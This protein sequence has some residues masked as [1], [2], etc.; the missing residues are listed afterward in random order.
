MSTTSTPAGARG[1]PGG[2]IARHDPDA[3]RADVVDSRRP[4]GVFWVALGLIVAFTAWAGLAPEALAGAMGGAMK[5]TTETVGWIYLAV[6]LACVLTLILLAFSPYGR[7]RLGPDGSRPD[8]STWSWLAMILSA[9]MGIGLISYGVAEPISHFV[10]PP[11]DLAE[12][13]TI[14]AAVRAL[15]FSFLDW[16]LHAWAIFGVFGLAIAY[17]THRK[18]R[19][20]LVSS[21]L[22]PVLGRHVDG[23]PG[24]AIDVFAIIATL[25][26]TTTSL[27]LGAST[28]GQGLERVLGI[29]A[30][31]FTLVVIIMAITVLFT[32]SALS[33]V[34]R[35]IKYLSSITFG[36]AVILGIYALI[37]GPTNFISTMFVRAV[38]RFLGE[39]FQISL[40]TP[41]SADELQWMQWWTYFMMAWWLSW[42]AFVGIFLAKI[43][44]GRTV[45]EFILG[46]MIVPT[47]VFFLWFS[48]FGGSAMHFD[49]NTGSAIGE[50]AT[51]NVTSAFFVTL[52]QLPLSA[53]TSVMA[54]IMVVLYF[55]T[56]AD[57]NTLVLG[58]LSSRGSLTPPRPVLL[59]WGVLTGVVAIVLMLLGGLSALQQAAIVSGLP[60]A[61][62]VCLLGYSLFRELVTDSTAQRFPDVQTQ[63]VN[64]TE[65]ERVV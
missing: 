60:L 53:I 41:T 43:S 40:M 56:S 48:I 25:F 32:L 50:A 9:V 33:G 24:K 5:W 58:M 65:A 59:T 16:G 18:G 31:T 27:G 26:G 11:H 1:V 38:G 54:V 6:P 61:I 49:M 45:R 30:D 15:Q 4:D 51:N 17:S 14:D 36:G 35:G 3:G 29:P 63:A 22:R 64:I 12:A 46:V 20:A 44:R 42:G 19:P 2:R 28:I 52:D 62:I 21:M 55:V 23:W 47:A 13:G 7:L 34:S 39:F 37:A 10:V 57:S 8:F